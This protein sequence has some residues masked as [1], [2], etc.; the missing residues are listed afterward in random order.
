MTFSTNDQARFLNLL[1]RNLL[2]DAWYPTLGII[3]AQALL[4]AESTLV[5]CLANGALV[6]L[7]IVAAAMFCFGFSWGISRRD[8]DQ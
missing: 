4:D 7:L 2:R 1:G 5:D 6:L 3:A 8:R